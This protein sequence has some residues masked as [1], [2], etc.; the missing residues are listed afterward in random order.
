MYPKTLLDLVA[1][2][3]ISFLSVQLY[4]LFY[5]DSFTCFFPILGLFFLSLVLLHYIGPLVKRSGEIRNLYLPSSLGEKIFNFQ[6]RVFSWYPV[7]HWSIFLSF[8][9]VF[10]MNECYILSPCIYWKNDTVFLFYSVNIINFIDLYS[11]MK[12]ALSVLA[13]MHHHNHLIMMY[14]LFYVLLDSIY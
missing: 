13:M 11:N 14:N 12:L 6:L 5:I 10:I 3:N 7:S 4:Y 9:S 1:S 8:Q 2:L